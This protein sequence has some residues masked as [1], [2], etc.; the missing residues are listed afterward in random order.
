[1]TFGSLMLFEDSAPFLQLSRAVIAS[2]VLVTT[3]FCLLVLYFVV[4]TQRRKFVSGREGMA[5]LTGETLTEVHRSGQVF[6]RGEYWTAFSVEPIAAGEVIEVVRLADDMRLEVR[7]S[8][9]DDSE[10]STILASGS[11]KEVGK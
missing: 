5:G 9:V 2:T 7:R 1:M 8:M 10:R 6:V 11:D 3:G 4:R